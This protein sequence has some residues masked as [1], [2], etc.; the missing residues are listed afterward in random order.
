MLCIWEQTSEKA[1]SVEFLGLIKIMLTG[2]AIKHTF[3]HEFSKLL[4]QHGVPEYCLGV[5]QLRNYIHLQLEQANDPEKKSYYQQCKSV[6]FER[7][8]GSRYFVSAA[9]AGK[10]PFMAPVAVE[11]LEYTGKHSGNMLE[12]SVYTKL[13]DS[14][15]LA[16]LKAD[17]II[18]HH[19][20]ADSVML[21]KSNDLH[22]SAFDM[23]SITWNSSAF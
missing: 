16:S 14:N 21:A 1:L 22:K 12:R 2:N 9:N 7:Q 17:A 13:K 8:V 15:E 10:I 5:L 23:G 11:F 4:S 6:T 20:Y 19:V 18:F 3:I